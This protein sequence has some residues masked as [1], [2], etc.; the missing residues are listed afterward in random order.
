[1][2]AR[3]VHPR[4]RVLLVGFVILGS[5]VAWVLLGV[6]KSNDTSSESVPS[7]AD[8]PQE[9]TSG[10]V[11]QDSGASAVL[12]LDS[13]GSTKEP[14]REVRVPQLS[15]P[16]SEKYLNATLDEL[17]AARKD[18]RSILSAE[19]KRRLD[20]QFELGLQRIVMASPG[21]EV[22]ASHGMIATQTRSTPLPSGESKVEIVEFDLSSDAMTSQ[23]LDEINWLSS[24]IVKLEPNLASPR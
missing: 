8:T 6:G 21:E 22:P 13:S 24:L 4:T 19:A 20:R 12:E 15:K 2:L 16:L 11:H 5:S 23:L 7:T 1:M 10:D 9:S 18:L 3:R 17:V 14:T